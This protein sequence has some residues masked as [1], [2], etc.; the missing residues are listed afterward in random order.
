MPVARIVRD[1]GAF[2]LDA[3]F[4]PPTLHLDVS[5]RLRTI[6]TR[7][8]E[9][10]VT[11]SRALTERQRDAAS[12]REFAPADAVRLGMLHV[13]NTHI[14]ALRHALEGGPDHPA[15]LFE[16]LASLA[17]GLAAYAPALPPPQS[18]PTYD[19]GAPTDAFNRLFD[20]IAGTLQEEHTS[21]AYERIALSKERDTLLTASLSIGQQ[22]S[23]QLLLAVR[24]EARTEDQ[25]VA[26][27]PHMLR[28]AAPSNI[29]QVINHSIS[30][31]RIE[32]T[33]RLPPGMPIDERASYFRLLKQGPF[34][35]VIVQ[36]G[37]L[38]I[39]RPA[40]YT[41]LEL[42]LIATS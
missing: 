3:S 22:Q 9:M 19:H 28:I 17:G 11:K 27:L 25:L 6:A 10:L 39:F 24:S 4:V 8:L 34:W 5:P 32:P 31:L 16:T 42:D 1:G 2:A 20:L 26:N 33:R 35:D 18:L 12:Q 30:A 21:D 29:E 7:T 23:A 15:A 41:D 38:A 14:P 36:E 37:A 13:V 40:D